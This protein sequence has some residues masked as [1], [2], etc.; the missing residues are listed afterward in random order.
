M[1]NDS[2]NTIVSTPM[3]FATLSTCVYMLCC[4][5][6]MYVPS[7]MIMCSVGNVGYSV[8]GGKWL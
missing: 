8:Y 5:M 7:E 4:Y 2:L 3:F 6:Y 1:N